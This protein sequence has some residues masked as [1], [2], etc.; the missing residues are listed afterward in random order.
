M[1]FVRTC[2][3]K[4]CALVKKLF[5]QKKKKVLALA[6][7]LRYTLLMFAT[8]YLTFGSETVSFSLPCTQWLQRSIERTIA[9]ESAKRNGAQPD[10]VVCQ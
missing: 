1:L 9:E 6:L 10:K 5:L 3:E 7:V 8:L 4:K 2:Q